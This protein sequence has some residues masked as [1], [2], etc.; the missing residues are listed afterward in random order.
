[1]KKRAVTS[2][3]VDGILTILWVLFIG[4]IVSPEARHAMTYGIAGSILPD[5]LVGLGEAFQQNKWFKKFSGLHFAIHSCLTTKIKK[6]WPWMVGVLFQLTVI[7]ILIR[8][9]KI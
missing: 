8:F 4:D 1:M 6:D 9:I 5:L 3:T 7:T 2:V